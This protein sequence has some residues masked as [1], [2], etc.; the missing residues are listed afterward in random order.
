MDGKTFRII[1]R[2]IGQSFPEFTMQVDI[3]QRDRLA[4]CFIGDTIIHLA[5]EHRDDVRPTTRYEQVNVEGTRNI[6]HAARI[7]GITRIIFTSSVAVYGFAEPDTGEDGAIRPFN[8]YGRTKFAAEQVLREWAGEDPTRR[9]LTIVRPTVV[10]GPGNRGNVF[11]LLQQ[12][13]SG[14]FLM[15]G[16]GTNRKSM[17]YVEN[18]VAFLRHAV[19]FGS[20]VHLFNYVDKP[21]PTMNELVAHVRETVL[22]KKGVGPRLPYSVGIALG[23]VSD[24]V[25]RV[26]ARAMPISSIR[27]R[28]FA[29]NT[30]FSSRA[31]TSPG[32]VAPL[33]LEEGLARTLDAEFLHPRLDLPVF[34]TE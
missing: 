32:F 27:V 3:L 25:S 21:D 1:D 14:R 28:K 31:H 13:A 26:T 17:A 2:R 4:Q 22:G 11:N 15:V 19:D 7:R 34:Y 18:L 5:A 29:S 10:F 9:S 30:A 16:N 23:Y 12:I 24:G 20:G 6:C 33:T 8:E